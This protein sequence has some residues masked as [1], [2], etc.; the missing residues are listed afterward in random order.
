MSNKI[1]GLSGGSAAS[2]GAG[3]AA[4]RTRD[5]VT[6]G[7]S[8]PAAPSSGTG[9][10][11]ITDSASQLAS[12]EQTLQSLPAVDAARVAQFSSAIEQGTYTVQPQHVADQLMQLEQ[13]LGQLPE[14]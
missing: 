14:G 8:A 3:R 7:S 10:V 5:P 9:D 1:S 2:I 6:G 4:E 12:L 13:A 11:H